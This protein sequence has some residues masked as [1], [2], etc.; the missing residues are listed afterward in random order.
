MTAG[1]LMTETCY[2][3]SNT[4]YE[5]CCGPLHRGETSARTA[6]QLMRSRYSG[7]VCENEA[8]LLATWHPS[9]RPSRVRFDSRQRWLGLRIK[10]TEQGLQGDQEGKVEFVARYKVD[11]RGHR[12]HEVSR[13]EVVDGQWFYLDGE[14]L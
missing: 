3:G 14:H 12:L 10:S 5:S 7:F 6:E 11:G 4:D 9:T 13:F 1:Q 2:C 8:Y